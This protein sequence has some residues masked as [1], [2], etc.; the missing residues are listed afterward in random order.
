MACDPTTYTVRVCNK[1]YLDTASEW[2]SP[3]RAVIDSATMIMT[4]YGNQMVADMNKYYVTII[5]T[6]SFGSTNYNVNVELIKCA[7]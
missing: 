4:I 6:N 2:T 3:V 5:A 1:D 7:M